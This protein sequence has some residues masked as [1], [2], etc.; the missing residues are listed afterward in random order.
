MKCLVQL[1]KQ[2]R[3]REEATDESSKKQLVARES[4]QKEGQ[5]QPK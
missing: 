1:A 2:K 3:R 5:K 4:R